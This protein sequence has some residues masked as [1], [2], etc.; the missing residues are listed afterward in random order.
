MVTSPHSAALSAVALK[1]SAGASELLPLLRVAHPVAFLNVCKA[2]GWRI[3]AAHAPKDFKKAQPKALTTSTLG[4]PLVDCPCLLILGSEGEGLQWKLQKTAN[5]T[6]SIEG[7]RAKDSIDS[8]NVS[9]AAA[10]LFEAFLVGQ[11]AH[12]TTQAIQ[13]ADGRIF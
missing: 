4:R 6:L 11:A 10:L 12:M 13:P 7:K 5:F 9:V 1:G 3:Y 2:N 8:L